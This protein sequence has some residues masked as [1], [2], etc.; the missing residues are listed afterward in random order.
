MSFKM[1]ETLQDPI[2]IQMQSIKFNTLP[3]TWPGNAWDLG[4][5][6]F[7]ENTKIPKGLNCWETYYWLEGFLVAKLSDKYS[8][9][10]DSN[11]H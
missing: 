5:K 10:F 4:K 8:K 2:W 1:D 9:R 6:A 7:Y 3:S 11:I